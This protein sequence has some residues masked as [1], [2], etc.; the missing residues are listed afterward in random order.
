MVVLRP[1]INNV[2]LAQLYARATNV[3]EGQNNR[4]YRSTKFV[5]ENFAPE[6]D[7]KKPVTLI[8]TVTKVQWTNPHAEVSFD[9]REASTNWILEL[10]SP[11]VGRSGTLCACTSNRGK[12]Q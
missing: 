2:R 3:G 12:T 7:W 10:G 6:F 5:A 11:R 9:T 8:G 1:S 4:H